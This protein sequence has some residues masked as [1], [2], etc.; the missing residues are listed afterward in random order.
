VFRGHF[1]YSPPQKELPPL[2]ILFVQ[3]ADQDRRHLRTDR[4]AHQACRMM[5][6]AFGLSLS[7][8]GV[9]S[10]LLGLLNASFTLSLSART[11][12]SSLHGASGSFQDFALLEHFLRG[13]KHWDVSSQVKNSALGRKILHSKTLYFHIDCHYDSQ[14]CT[15]MTLNK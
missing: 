12:S 11:S 1:L 9:T 14:F 2:I 7:G 5:G 8:H 13:R 10:S 3:A 6:L 15:K 4:R